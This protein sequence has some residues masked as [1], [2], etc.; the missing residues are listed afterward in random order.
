[1]EEINIDKNDFESYKFFFNYEYLRSGK[2]KDRTKKEFAE[3]IR[4][5]NKYYEKDKNSNFGRDKV[6][7][8][9]GVVVGTYTNKAIN[10]ELE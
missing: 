5:V 1:M 3:T 10:H 2:G 8:G 9:N 4:E 7:E 6:V